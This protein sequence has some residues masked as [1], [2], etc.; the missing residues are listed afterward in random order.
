MNSIVFIAVDE[1][2]AINYEI[3]SVSR[4]GDLFELHD[5]GLL[6]SIL[7]MIKN[8][9]YYPNYYEKMSHLIFSI[10]KNHCFVDGNTRPSIVL[11]AIFLLKMGGLLNPLNFSFFKWKR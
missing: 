4:V 2:I 3:I 10:Y 9:L 5:K 11:G 1:T 6:I 8:D 7:T